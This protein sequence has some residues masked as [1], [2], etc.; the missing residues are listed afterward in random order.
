MNRIPTEQELEALREAYEREQIE[1]AQ[2]EA[3]EPFNDES[4]E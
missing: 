2:S 4:Q 1:T 3:C